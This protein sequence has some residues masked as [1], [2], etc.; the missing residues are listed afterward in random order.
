MWTQSIRR[1]AAEGVTTCI[2]VGPGAVLTGMLR[3]I[4]TNLKGLKFGEAAD[5]EK[6]SA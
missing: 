4:D 1:L 6:L 5:L 3:S 2:E